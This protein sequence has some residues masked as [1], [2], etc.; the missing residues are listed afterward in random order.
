VNGIYSVHL[1]QT[2]NLLH[3][4]HNLHGKL[5][6]AKPRSTF[7]FTG[8]QALEKRC[9]KCILSAK[10]YVMQR[11]M[12]CHEVTKYDLN[13]FRLTVSVCELFEWPSYTSIYGHIRWYCAKWSL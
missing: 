2:T 4:L 1:Y 11:N 9:T 5:L 13:I 3:A 8:I 7:F 10:K 12:F 6:A